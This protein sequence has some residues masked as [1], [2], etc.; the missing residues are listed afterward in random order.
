MERKNTSKS[1]LILGSVFIVIL[2]VIAALINTKILIISGGAEGLLSTI[3]GMGGIL[4]LFIGII[5]FIVEKVRK[6]KSSQDIRNE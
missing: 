5:K 2:I 1:W 6:P 3:F 4:F